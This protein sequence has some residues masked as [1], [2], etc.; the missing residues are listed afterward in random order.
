MSRANWAA[1]QTQHRVGYHP[2]PAA[3]KPKDILVTNAI[4]MAHECES[5]SAGTHTCTPSCPT[6]TSPAGTLMMHT[7]I[8]FFHTRYS[9]VIIYI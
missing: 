1:R 7:S 4:A 3:D 8:M 5:V 2:H 6:E 9:N